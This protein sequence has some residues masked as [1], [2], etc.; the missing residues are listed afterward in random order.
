M[1]FDPFSAFIFLAS[2]LFTNAS[3]RRARREAEKR[4]AQLKK[5]E[6][7]GHLVNT[8]TTDFYY[9]LIYGT[10][11]VGGN[12]VYDGPAGA[13]DRY[14]CRILAVGMGPM[15]GIVREDGSI[16]TTTGTQIPSAQRPAHRPV[17]AVQV[18]EYCS[19][20]I[21]GHSGASLTD[22]DFGNKIIKIV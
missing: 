22:I 5:L 18:T 21:A 8:R 11:R 19:V 9:P 3:A 10:V 4:Q 2:L 16:Y 14:A 15:E 13:G 1:A 12:Y 7:S 17:C 6:K 20:R